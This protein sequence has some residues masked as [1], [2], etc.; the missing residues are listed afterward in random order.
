[1]TRVFDFVLV[2]RNV[3]NQDGVGARDIGVIDGKIAEIGDL[4][5]AR[6]ASGSTAAACTSCPA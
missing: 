4:G 2:R 6:P 5:R 1:M 3:V